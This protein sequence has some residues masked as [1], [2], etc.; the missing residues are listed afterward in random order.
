MKDKPFNG[1]NASQ[2]QLDQDEEGRL[3]ISKAKDQVQEAW[4]DCIQR[5]RDYKAAVKYWESIAYHS[6]CGHHPDTYEVDK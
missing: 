2:T 1:S 6:T 5:K 3:I 4:D